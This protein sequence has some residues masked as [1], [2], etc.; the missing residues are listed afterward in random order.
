MET[1]AG[2]S[3]QF[4]HAAETGSAE[5]RAV[6]TLSMRDEDAPLYENVRWLEHILGRVIRRLEGDQVFEAV[7]TLRARCAD[8][9]NPDT[10]D[11]DL[12]DLLE[13]VN[14]LSP[15]L[16]R[17][18]AR[19]FTLFFLLM[20]TAEQVHRVRRRATYRRGADNP[21][22]GSPRW[23]FE[24]LKARGISTEKIRDAVTRLEVRPVLTAHPTEATR[25]TV[26]ELQ[27]RLAQALLER[28]DASEA[29]L[30]RLEEVIEGEVELLWLTD[31]VR[32]DRP[33]VADEVAN[34]VWYLEQR[35]LQASDWLDFT[36]KNTFKQVFSE[37]LGQSVKIPVGSWVGGD[38]DGN[39]FVTPETTF[40]AIRRSTST[41]MAHYQKRIEEL[42]ARLSISDRQAKAPDALRESI[43]R[44]RELL[45]EV[46]ES[47][48]RR[49]SE[50]PIRLK[51]SFM[52][53]RLEATRHEL[54]ALEQGR[55][56][57]RRGSYQK[58]QE[59]VTDLELIRD[60]LEHVGADYARASLLQPLLD[61][62]RFLGFAGYRLD[63][64]EDSEE[65]TSAVNT[66]TQEL[67]IDE[68][69]LVAMRQELGGRRPLVNPNLPLPEDT[70]KVLR[71]FHTMR[72]A[73][74]QY[75]ERVAKTYIISMARKEED[76]LRVLLLAR[77]AGLVDLAAET[78]RSQI[79]VVPLFETRNDLLNGPKVLDALC[80]DPVYQRQLDARLRRQEVMLGYSD[81]SKDVGVLC[82]AWELYRAQEEL[83][84]VAKKHDL[85][86]TLFHGR[87]GTVGRGGG[88]PVY[89]ALMALPPGTIG[90]RIKITEQ[91]EIISQKFG[92]PDIAERSLEVMFTGSLMAHFTDWR[93]GLESGLEEQFREVMERLSA[94]SA[95]IYRRL[96]H[97]EKDVFQMFVEA[98]P[99]R[100]LAHVHFGSRPVYRERKAGSMAGIRAIPWMFGWTQNRL[101]LP[102]WLGAGTALAAEAGRKG[103][104][105]RMQLMAQRW[106][107]FDDLLGKIEMV[108]AKADIDTARLYVQTLH[109]NEQL[110]GELK[111]ELDRTVQA[112]KAIRQRE[113]LL[114]SS[115]VLRSEIQLRNPYVDSLNLLQVS[116]LER[117]RQLPEDSEERR[118]VEVA[119][120][121][122]LNGIAQGMR[123]TG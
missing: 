91:G 123:N 25:R 75:G 92:I 11:I 55:K 66:I 57:Q 113:R 120:G 18:V 88:S 5:N 24:Q 38:R 79:D 6:K 105:Q 77:E 76:L 8:R 100:E 14:A 67:G 87:G 20:N 3:E 46:W 122:T 65:H 81:S 45:Y 96:V 112:I 90:K 111:A 101:I 2:D 40:Y 94:E 118:L 27:A 95:P 89:R 62:V 107:F 54:A 80:Q 116:L 56:E 48:V 119:L 1:L 41:L 74:A 36:V 106:P 19:A 61:Q 50:E 26:L 59:L 7:D 17:P 86:L 104:L 49:D 12:E 85:D 82:A 39:P 68:L 98:T 103:G 70:E 22:P 110:F 64:R 35:L 121:T 71:V 10:P 97:E 109:D 78:P 42:M 32:R 29:Q 69:D 21:Q 72:K 84:E 58:N 117:K 43:Q 34:S 99:V 102:A 31:E 47:N 44:D 83:T 30:A 53:A 114:D 93:D 108:C 73:Q 37:E 23:A 52:V 63:V 15:A 16:A 9:R 51:L 60:A 115:A 4:R 13:T 33:S 28:D